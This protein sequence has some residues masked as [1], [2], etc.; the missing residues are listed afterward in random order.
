MTATVSLLVS[1]LRDGGMYSELTYATETTH[2]AAF[3]NPGY[4][5]YPPCTYIFLNGMHSQ[6]NRDF[7]CIF[8]E[9]SR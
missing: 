8:K 2:L 1:K 9:E 4:Q 5:L 7:F 3:S 6:C